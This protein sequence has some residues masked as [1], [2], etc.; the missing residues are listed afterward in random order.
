MP[1][2]KSS[3]AKEILAWH[4]KNNR[5]YLSWRE[6]SDPYKILVAEVLLQKTDAPKVNQIY[7][8]F[9]KEYPD[10]TS[11]SK[12]SV[13]AIRGVIKPLGLYHHRSH[14]LKKMALQIIERHRG[15]IPDK[16]KDLMGL[17]GVGEYTSNAVLCFGFKR[18][19][20]LID[21]NFVRVFSRILGYNS[22]K[23]RPWTDAK[24]WEF[25][26]DVIPNGKAK[27]FN[28]AVLDFASLICRARN[29]KHDICPFQRYCVY[30]Q[31]LKM[32]SHL[33]R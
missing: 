23:T 19:V 26:E 10:V 30:Y 33:D 7:S 18:D 14:R 9:I 17:K 24:L 3:F 32:E 31:S 27:E 22:K 1:K 6:T 15:S 2:C 4:K 20:P 25:A 16:K 29:P 12:T 11:L 21:T 13:E 8:E 5:N 28:W